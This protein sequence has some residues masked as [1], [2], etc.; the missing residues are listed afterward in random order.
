[1][2]CGTCAYEFYVNN[3]FLYRLGHIKLARL[4]L[5]SGA[6]VSSVDRDAGSV[7]FD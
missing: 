1:V 6:N 3:C 4:L 2:Y 7:N 5:V